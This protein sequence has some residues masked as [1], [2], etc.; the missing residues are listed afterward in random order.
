MPF[1]LRALD[2][3]RDDVDFFAPQV[4]ALAGMRI[5]AGHGNAR[6]RQAEAQAQ[7]VIEDRAGSAANVSIDSDA[8]TLASGRCV[9]ASATRSGPCG[10]APASIITTCAV[11]CPLGQVLGVS[12][13]R[14]AGVVDR[15]FSAPAR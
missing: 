10:V 2:R 12:G 6:M 7:I 15:R 11:R 14:N 8:L 1:A 4:T 3:R 9:V 13:K 5:E